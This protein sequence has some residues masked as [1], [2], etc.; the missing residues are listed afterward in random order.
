VYH[1]SFD[2]NPSELEFPVDGQKALSTKVS[3][4]WKKN[5]NA[6][7]Y[8]VEL[9]DSPSFNNILFTDNLEVLTTD[10]DILQ[11]NAVYYWR[12]K[13]KNRCGDGEYSSTFSFQTGVTDCENTYTATDFST[14]TIDPLLAN[15]TATVPINI[16]ENLTVNKVIL[17]TDISHTSVNELT[18]SIEAPVVNGGK[19]TLLSNACNPDVPNISNTT[20]DDDGGTLFCGFGD[21]A[22][23]GTIMPVNNM[24]QPFLG[25]SA[26]GEWIIRVEDNAE[27]NGGQINAV[28]ITICSS[29]E[30]TS[31][32]TFSSSSLVLD[33]NSDYIVT[34]T[35]MNASTASETEE[36]QVYTL[37]ELAKK[38]VLK[39]DGSA[40]IA[41]DTFTQADITSGKITFTNSETG[42]FTDQFKVDVTNDA[43][44]W[45]PNQTITI[46]EGV[47]K[48]NE[49]SLNEVSLW[50][51]PTKGVLN[52]KIINVKNEDVKISLFD[53][54]GRKITTSIN[55]VTNT[56]FTKEI[57]TKN[58]SSGVYLLSIEQGN[59]KATKK[60]IISN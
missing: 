34:V 50:P 15:V 30:N 23:S 21:P 59:K 43:K 51:N 32:P 46:Q 55:K 12:V 31:I 37:V 28:S 16:S 26:L 36:Q 53:L 10:V 13:P 22:I 17:T 45:L 57:E 24:S 35:N 7:S 40:L 39:K 3:L 42:S 52:V 14:A 2:A 11:T 33:G 5:L 19:V 60:V 9:S 4:L 49:F 47:L 20:F 8:I 18:I 6:E 41:G 56:T 54:Q 58:I 44:G 38:G 27:L 48:I 1:P 29:V 25:K